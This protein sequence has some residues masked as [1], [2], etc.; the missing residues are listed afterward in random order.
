MI[1]SYISH[2]NSLAKRLYR[3]PAGAAHLAFPAPSKDAVGNFFI[4]A[5]KAGG[6]IHGEPKLRDPG[7]GYYS[8][9]VIDSDGNSIEAVYRPSSSS[10]RS[11]ATGPD[12]PLLESGSV[13][14]KA[15]SRASS[16][17][18]ESIAPPR[19]EARSSVSKATTAVERA[20]PSEYSVP[21]SE[22][23]APSVTTRE[24]HQPVSSPTYV[25]NNHTTHTTQT[26]KSDDGNPTAKT[27]V[28]SLIGAAAGAALAYAWT[29]SG[30]SESP[31]SESTAP[32]QHSPHEWAALPSPGSQA[33]SQAQEPQQGFFRAIEAAPAKSTYSQS[34]F[35]PTLTRSV[36]SKNP[37]AS[38]I[39]EGTEYA[40]PKSQVGSVYSDEN[41]RRASDGSVYSGL[42]DL[43]LRAIEY[44]PSARSGSHHGGNS[45]APSLISSFVD[46][47]RAMNDD[48]RS[49]YSSSTAKPS[50]ANYQDDR[51]SYYAP[52]N[53][54]SASKSKAGGSTASSNRTA[55][56]IPLPEGSI[57][58][59]TSYRSGAK[60]GVS[61]RDVPLP[62]GSVA[63]YRSG[64]KS[65]VSARDVPLPEG[66]VAS[67]YRSGAKSHV[68]ARDVPLPQGSV[69]SFATYRSGAK[70]GISARDVP[71]PESV[72]GVDV[73]THVTPDDSISQIDVGGGDD[74]RKSSYSAA[75][76]S[77]T[78]GG[79]GSSR[80]S[81]PASK[82]D[83]PVRP[84]DSVSQISSHS[85]SSQRTVKASGQGPP[86]MVAGGSGGSKVG[87]GSKVSSSRRASQVA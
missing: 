57:A 42:R 6:K 39:Y 65:G 41:G 26:Q 33:P 16:A 55:R 86:S 59:F 40:P 1:L 62:E 56:N 81:K 29:S 20:A 23:P 72:V 84:S 53:H 69:A 74:D 15:S 38:T 63:S 43:P 60:S 36:T 73:N 7:S 2:L 70:S 9:A 22:K 78:G 25:M 48:N 77:K 75:H 19:S 44:A 83:E 37:R 5:L 10:A 3:V 30:D 82:F 4:S 27:I 45:N 49:V 71:L 18:P 17:K 67:S 66:S 64:A 79:S 46:Q 13:V 85:K 14:S 8:A 28:G 12:I 76:R 35:R 24:V 61:A 80:V 87:G 50:K 11:E 47:S 34:E 51:S 58:S 52:S 21:P 54:S 32:P 68:S 31:S